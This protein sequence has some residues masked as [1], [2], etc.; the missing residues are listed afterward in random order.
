M[1]VEGGQPE[2]TFSVCAKACAGGADNTGIFQQVVKEIPALHPVWAFH[3]DIGGV[4]AAGITDAQPVK[5]IGKDTGVLPVVVDVGKGLTAAFFRKD[6]FCASLDDVG[7]AVEFGGLASE[8]EAVEHHTAAHQRFGDNGI[9]A[10][11]AGE[12]GRLGEGAEFNC[13][14]FCTLY[15]IDRARQCGISDKTFICRVKQDNCIPFF[16]IVDPCFQTSVIIY[17][18]GRIVGRTDIDDIGVGLFIRQRQKTVGCVGVCKD[19]P[20]AGH[21]V[22]VDINRVDRIG[23]QYTVIGIKQVKNIAEVGFCAVADKDLILFQ[24]DITLRIIAGNFSFQEVISLFRSI[25]AEGLSGTHLSA[26]AFQCLDDCR[27]EGKSDIADAQPDDVDIWVL[28]LKSRHFFANHCKEVA[29]FQLQ[30]MLIDFH[31]GS[32]LQIYNYS[33]KQ[34]SGCFCYLSIFDLF[35]AFLREAA[36]NA[37]NSG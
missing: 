34:P 15:L 28:L 17:R 14:L 22:G 35:S 21:D 13:D 37:R 12:P 31:R 6:S 9:T 25:T 16:R 2:I 27:T 24:C 11:G 8:P 20:P 33:L 29:F 1:V 23:N 36:I 19:D 18:T 4:F 32:S 5:G 30:I 10:A 7:N 26:G 3:P